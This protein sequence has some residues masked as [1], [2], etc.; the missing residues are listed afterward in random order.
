MGNEIFQI[1]PV[2]KYRWLYLL[3]YEPIKLDHIKVKFDFCQ[4]AHIF[5][6]QMV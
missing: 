5:G 3:K 6:K 1:K 2:L 4:A